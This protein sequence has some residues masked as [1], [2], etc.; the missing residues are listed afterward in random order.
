METDQTSLP[1]VALKA[2]PLYRESLNYAKQLANTIRSMEELILGWLAQDNS[3]RALKRTIVIMRNPFMTYPSI[4]VSLYEAKDA[5]AQISWPSQELISRCP[6]FEALDETADPYAD[7]DGYRMNISWY[8]QRNLKLGIYTDER[9][10]RGTALASS[11]SELVLAY[12]LA[13]HGY[14]R[15][16]RKGK[17]GSKIEIELVCFGAELQAGWREYMQVDLTEFREFIEDQNKDTAN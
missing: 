5:I 11:L 17:N 6:G 8:E 4:G 15:L 2:A 3:K 16:Y 12:A 13:T 7:Q 10:K 14:A 1:L 9:T